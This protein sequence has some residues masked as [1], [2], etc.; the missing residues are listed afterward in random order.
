M[1]K[2]IQYSGLNKKTAG[3]NTKKNEDKLFEAVPNPFGEGFAGDRWKT[4]IS[5]K[6]K[7]NSFVKINVYDVLGSKI[8]TLVNRNLA[9]GNHSV[10][11]YARDLPAGIYYYTMETDR[12]FIVKK[13]N[14]IK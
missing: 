7:E 14:L 5:F 12:S 13:L 9:A 1:P 2:C 11:F 4:T 3:D 6:L 8:Q 10:T